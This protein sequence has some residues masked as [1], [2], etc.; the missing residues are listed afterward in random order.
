MSRTCRRADQAV[1]LHAR[2][3]AEQQQQLI[4]SSIS[5]PG[6]RAAN[7]KLSRCASLLPAAS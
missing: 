1:L 7:D 6:T 5:Q 2:A 4:A 3:L